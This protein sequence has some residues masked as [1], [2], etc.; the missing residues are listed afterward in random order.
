[1]LVWLLSDNSLVQRPAS[2]NGRRRA[3]SEESPWPGKS[4]AFLDVFR[5]EWSRSP[6]RRA[7]TIRRFFRRPLAPSLLGPC[8][9]GRN[10]SWP[11]R[12]S[13]AKPCSPSRLS[14][15]ALVAS[16]RSAS[17]SL[18]RE[19]AAGQPPSATA[20]QN[21]AM[22]ADVAFVDAVQGWAVGD[23]G[24]IWHTDD[25]GAHWQLQPSGVDAPLASICF[26]DEQRGLG[27]WRSD[28]TVHR[29]DQR[30]HLAHARRRRTLDRRAQS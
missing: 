12:H 17:A 7:V 24:V 13:P 26:L 1:M 14:W 25:G 27:G 28:A 3:A 20:M 9:A 6:R 29:L 11:A 2:A 4:P 18:R 19:A 5:R 10:R 16:S 21:D 15:L 8:R 30:R 23:R 22:L